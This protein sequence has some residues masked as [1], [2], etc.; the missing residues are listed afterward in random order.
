[1]ERSIASFTEHLTKRAMALPP[2]TSN[3]SHRRLSNYGWKGLFTGLICSQLLHSRLF[4]GDILLNT[5]KFSSRFFRWG[6]N[7]FG[8][9]VFFN[10]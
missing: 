3:K 5:E 2:S 4:Y 8:G 7:Y 6:G 1:M 9:G 10:L